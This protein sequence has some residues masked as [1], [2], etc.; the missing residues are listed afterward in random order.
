MKNNEIVE[1]S[2]KELMTKLKDEK[3]RLARMQFN[4]TVAPIEDPSQIKATKITIARIL[5]EMR[6]RRMEGINK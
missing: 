2:S 1:L 6:K 4:H 3:A 5:T